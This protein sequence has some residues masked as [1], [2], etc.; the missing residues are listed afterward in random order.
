[1]SDDTAEREVAHGDATHRTATVRTRH[2]DAPLVAAALAPDETD[3]MTTRVD[4]DAIECVVERPTTG[5]LRSTVDDHVVNLRVADRIVERA[6]THL[7][8]DDGARRSD[9]NG[10]TDTNT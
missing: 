1:M 3:S 10:D 6:R 8:T 2:A 5:G 9:T 4:G 7:A